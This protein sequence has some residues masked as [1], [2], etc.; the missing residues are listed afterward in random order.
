MKGKRNIKKLNKIITLMFSTAAIAA[1]VPGASVYASEKTAYEIDADRYDGFDESEYMTKENEAV[2]DGSAAEAEPETEL[3]TEPEDETKDNIPAAADTESTTETDTEP[4]YKKEFSGTGATDPDKGDDSNKEKSKDTEDPEDDTKIPDGWQTIDGKTYYYQ[5]G[6]KY[7]GWLFEKKD[8][9][10]IKDGEKYTG[11]QLMDKEEGEKTSHYSYFGQDGK[12]RTG[13]VHLGK[14]T[15][16]P[17]GNSSAHWSYFGNNGWLRTGWVEMGKGTADPDGNVTRHW[18]YFGS[19]GWLRTGWV[20]LGKGTANP[21]GNGT[22]HWSYFGNNGWLR[23][24]WVEMGKGTAD[25]DGNVTR[26]WS[27]FGNNGWLR[28][29][30]VEMG[31]GTADPDGNVTRHWSYFGSN[32]WLRTGWVNL[33]K[34]TANPDGNS[35]AHWSYFGNNGWM[36]TGWVQMGKGTSEP[37]GNSTAHWSYFG[38]NG[39]LNTGTARIAGMTC[40][41]NGSGWLRR[42]ETVTPHFNQHAYGYPTGCGATS[43]FMALRYKGKLTNWSLPQFMSTMPYTNDG[44]PNNGFVGSPTVYNLTPSNRGIYPAALARWGARYGN[45]SDISGCTVDYMMNEVRNGNPVVALATW[46]LSNYAITQYSWG[47]YRD[48]NHHFFVLVGYDYNTDRYKVMDALL[49]TGDGS[50][51]V[52]GASF[53]NVWNGIKGAVV[54]RS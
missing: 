23:T 20:H 45:V 40:T 28:T 44:N 34:G 48:Y 1:V 21:D 12:L 37:D 39:W 11:W 31:K 17:D 42:Y 8:C 36:R 5:N 22:A 46:N 25:P 35:T 16:D 27:Y 18:S 43:L 49:S 3:K 14:G 2:P 33:G 54:V 52:T 13:W 41:F 26:H 29:G 7:T 6:K 19:N 32:G 38:N 51:W 24:G 50:K 47:K 15:A 9:F 4:V 10:Y 53:R 30:W